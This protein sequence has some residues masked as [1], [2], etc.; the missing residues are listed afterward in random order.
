MNHEKMLYFH[1]TFAYTYFITVTVNCKN[2]NI[3]EIYK[4]FKYYTHGHDINSHLKSVKE[5]H[6]LRYYILYFTNKELN[7]SRIIRKMSSYADI[8]IRL[9]R[10]TEEDIEN[11]IKFKVTSI[12]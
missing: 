11:I 3:E 10:K 8:Q 1:S 5:N 12:L 6:A 9:V 7:Y 4:K 2:C